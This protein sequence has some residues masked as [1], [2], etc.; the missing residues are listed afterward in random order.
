VT[1]WVEVSEQRLVGNFRTLAAAVGPET[2]ILAVVKAN[3]YG[4]GLE[5]CCAVLATAGARWLGVTCASEGARARKVLDHLGFVRGGPRTPEILVMSGSF[6]EDV[7]VIVSNG[8][9]AV[10]WTKEQ[11][12]WLSKAKGTRV[13]L[14]ID[15]GMSRQGVEL[16]RPMEE[17]LN[18]INSAGLVLDGVFTHFY[19]AEMAHSE[20]TEKQQMRFEQAIGH[21]RAWVKAGAERGRLAPVW[22]HAGNSSTVDN[23]PQKFPWLVRQAATL[24]AKPMVRSGLALYGYCL[25]I[26]QAPVVTKAPGKGTVEARLRAR[27]APVMTWKT[28]LLALREIGRDDAVGY[29]PSFVAPGPMRIGLLPVGYADGLRRE[30][31]SSNR[32]PGGWAMVL[33]RDPTEWRG[34]GKAPERK[35][36]RAPI[37]GR[38]S[39]NLTVVDVT[40]IDDVMVG[41]DV[42]LLG[43]GITAEDHAHLAR[44]I[45][46]E[47]LCGVRQR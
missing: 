21:V 19:A 7:P 6:P 27:L 14:E 12:E 29:G 30:L 22:V 15:T 4:H 5:D 18:R 35:Y 26:E 20:R 31:S 9:T 39:M 38:V 25:P 23:P 46:Y 17:M 28:K 33:G 42:V 3:A 43:D 16:G 41:D 1:S 40:A 36:L 10:V 13:H 11:V 34:Q 47:I 37:V 45:P 2:A 24:G 8:L 44:T 32:R